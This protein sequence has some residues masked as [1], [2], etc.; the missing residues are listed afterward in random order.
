MT[1]V[2]TVICTLVLLS[3]VAFVPKHFIVK[4]IGQSTL[5]K[6]ISN[7]TE[8][9]VQWISAISVATISV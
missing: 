2:T 8:P 6:C 5:N 7:S 1:G 4:K 3:N 9:C